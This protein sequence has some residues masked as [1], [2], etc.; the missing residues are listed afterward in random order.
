MLGLIGEHLEAGKGRTLLDIAGGTGNYAAA[1][2]THGFRVTVVDASPEMLARSFGKVGPGRQVV[3]DALALPFDDHTFDTVMLVS[4]LHLM[5]DPRK[6]LR[7][8]RRVLGDGPFVLQVFAKENIEPLF[9]TEYF[10][11]AGVLPHLHPRTEEIAAWLREAGFPEVRSAPYVYRG[12]E[13]GSLPALHT[14]A[15][16]LADPAYLRNNSWFNELADEDRDRG[17]ARLAEDLRSGRLAERVAQSLEVAGRT[18]HGTVFVAS[19]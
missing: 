2:A 6:A 3:A 11:G 14:E 1:A 5:A 19:V 7:E 15:R 4:A 18:G 9:V 12:L 8:A 10:E 16:L 17:L 13:D